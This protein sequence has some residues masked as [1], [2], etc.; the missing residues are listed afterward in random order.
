VLRAARLRDLLGIPG[1]STASAL[2]YRDKVRMKRCWAQAGIPAAE[3][4]ALHTPG[5]LLAFA[6]RVGYPIVVKPRAG[7]GSM[8]VQVLADRAQARA[9]LAA[10]FTHTEDGRSPWMAEAYIHG[11]MLQ[12]DGVYRDQAAEVNWPTAVSSLLECFQGQPVL[13]VTLAADDPLVPRVQH[14]VA[15][16]LAA[17]PDPQQPIVFH[18]EVWVDEHNTILMNEVAARIG[19]GQTR[20]IVELAFGVDLVR[21]YVE[22]AVQGAPTQTVPLPRGPLRAVGEAAIPPGR[23]RLHTTPPLPATLL[24]APW[25]HSASITAVP[26]RLYAGAATSVDSVAQCLVT[27]ADPDQVA[28]RLRHFTDWCRHHLRYEHP[29][30]DAEEAGAHNTLAAA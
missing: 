3:H 25:M 26:G 2:A 7:M 14:L 11:T 22:C 21:R 19:G 13:S 5:D 15:R 10:C 17:L 4:A 9:W 29:A 6:D 23:G 28:A 18:A 12:V 27:G 24:T 16:A 1:Q 8:R 20:Q 30:A